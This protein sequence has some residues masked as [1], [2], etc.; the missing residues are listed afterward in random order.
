MKKL[1]FTI[2][3]LFFILN[4]ILNAQDVLKYTGKQQ[5]N[6]NFHDGQLPHAIGVHNIQVM[7][8]NR[9]KPSLADG[10]GWTYNHNQNIAYWN[11]K[12]Y[13]HYLSTPYAEHHQPGQTML[14]TSKDGYNW[15]FPVVVFPQYELPLGYSKPGSTDAAYPG[16]HS[17]MHQRMGFHVSKKNRLLTFG[18]YGISFG[19]RDNPNKGDG[20][21]RVV[22]EIYPDGS[23]GDIFFIRY[24]KG[25]S[26]KNTKYPFYT[27]S[28]DK[29]FIEACNEVLANKLIIQ[30]WRE[31]A[32]R[33]DPLVSFHETSDFGA[34]G[35]NRAF[36]FYHLPD[37]RVVGLWKH[38][39][40]SIS[41][42]EGATWSEV[43][44][45]E[46]VVD[47]GAKFWG[48]KTSDG[49]YA[50]SYTPDAGKR[51]PLAV[52]TSDDG[53][54]YNKL[55]SVQGEV[56]PLRYIGAY[57]DYG[58]QYVRGIIEGNGTPP[59]GKMWL[60]YS[61]NKEDIWVAS[62]S[63]P[64][65]STENQDVSD[66]FNEM[67]P[68]EELNRWNTYSPVWAPVRIEKDGD[69]IRNLVLRDKDR[70]DF[71]KAER[72]FKTGKNTKIDFN[73]KPMQDNGLLYVEIH[74]R[75]GEAA[76][77]MLFDED[78]KFKVSNKQGTVN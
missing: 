5:T 42:D 3:G 13:V 77:T 47:G 16:M 29:G 27:R 19:S 54:D 18:Y 66:V 24:N 37:G 44:S 9:D 30:Q 72:V 21:G 15:D 73:I 56:S 12:F 53:L 74:D 60:V 28:K 20:I 76:I 61:M 46:N 78:G 1:F 6:I 59:D 68:G 52:M 7:R 14:V 58:P 2:A 48:Q 34:V 75:K 63:V 31:E 69:N 71:S 45:A 41:S 64:V 55:L 26:E 49:R 8:A 57:K 50:I 40:Y 62:V 36:N 38:A 23:F 11:G 10:Y 67:K 17:I 70:Y 51:F 25:F 65:I 32:D 43:K 33:D 35:V 4:T 22:R 39:M